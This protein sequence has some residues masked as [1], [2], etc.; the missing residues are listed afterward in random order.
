MSPLTAISCRFRFGTLLEEDLG[1]RE[2]KDGASD[3][4]PIQRPNALSKRWIPEQVEDGIE[5]YA[6]SSH[7]LEWE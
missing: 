6:D 4:R 5:G 1:I 3:R 2:E 7:R